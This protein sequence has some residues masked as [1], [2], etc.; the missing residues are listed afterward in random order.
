[1]SLSKHISSWSEDRNTK[2]GSVIADK[3]NVI[4]SVGYNRFPFGCDSDL[5]ER[6]ERPKK[7][8]YI[9]H[10]ERLS[11]YNA[12]RNGISVKGCT[13]YVMW[14]PCSDCARGII[15]SGIDTVV[16]NEPDFTD[17]R[18]GE[19]F[20]VTKELFDECGIIVRYI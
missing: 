12:A 5:D 8:M 3:D 10:A 2:V 14:Y 20:K 19:Q 1:M 9:E 13:I 16:C 4:V 15:Q 11:I 6:H 17:P 18:W 7:Y